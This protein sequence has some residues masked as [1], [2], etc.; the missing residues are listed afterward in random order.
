M[1]ENIIAWNVANWITIVL[2]AAIGFFLIGLG[3]KA[4]QQRQGGGK[5]VSSQ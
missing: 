1:N 4:Y 3:Q 5:V 2:M